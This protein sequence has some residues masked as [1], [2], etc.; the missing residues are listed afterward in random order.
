[1]LHGKY[2]HLVLQS[3]F[4]VEIVGRGKKY[5]DHNSYR[6]GN[7]KCERFVTLCMFNTSLGQDSSVKF[8]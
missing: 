8:G 1:M 5:A 6:I 3:S 7:V 2:V 4:G